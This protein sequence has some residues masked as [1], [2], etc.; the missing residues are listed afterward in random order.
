MRNLIIARASMVMK[1]TIIALFFLASAYGQSDETKA[2]QRSLLIYDFSNGAMTIVQNSRN[3]KYFN[4]KFSDYYQPFY[5]PGNILAAR[6][7]K[8]DYNYNLVNS[9]YSKVYYQELI[10]QENTIELNNWKNKVN[11]FVSRK[12]NSV[13]WSVQTKY[14]IEV[15]E[16]FFNIYK[17][18]NIKKE[19]ILLQNID[20]ELNRIKREY[21]GT[22]HKT[23]RYF[24]ILQ[25]LSDLKTC[26]PSEI[27]NISFRYG[28]F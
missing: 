8:F 1:N 22:F 4:N 11:S 23:D 16:Y 20:N 2:M 25:A 27:E 12:L 18:E 7:A 9:A 3:V 19:I 5:S 10:N 17:R 14:A 24:E 15:R 28:L 21:P 13:D 26:K 6:Q